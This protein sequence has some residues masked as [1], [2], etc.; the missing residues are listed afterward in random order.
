MDR[1]LHGRTASVNGLEHLPSLL[2]VVC[3]W[4]ESTSI[5][6]LSVLLCVVLLWTESMPIGSASIVSH[7]PD[8]PKA[9]NIVREHWVDCVSPHFHGSTT[10]PSTRFVWTTRS[11]RPHLLVPA[12]C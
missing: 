12:T 8:A 10:P 6:C 4:I 2:W 1:S 9:S 3:Q 5:V 11:C 7:H